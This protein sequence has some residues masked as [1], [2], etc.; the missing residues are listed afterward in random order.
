MKCIIAGGRD[1]QLTPSDIAKLDALPITE[2]V[3]G[4]ARGVDRDGEAWARS[5]G[6]AVKVFP[7]LWDEH[8]LKAGPI[9]NRAMAQYADAVVLFKG[10]RG[11]SNMF[12]EA[13]KARIEVY[14]CR[15]GENE[16]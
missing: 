16:S 6:I 3:S 15:K 5:R 12:I 7:A 10:G 1:Y 8:G 4:G 9:R 2:V 14:D 13:T 11:T